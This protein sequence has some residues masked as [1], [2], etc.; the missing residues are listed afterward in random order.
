M[1]VGH[2][3]GCTAHAAKQ[4]SKPRIIKPYMI[5]LILCIVILPLVLGEV[6]M[7]MREVEMHNTHF[8]TVYR[9]LLV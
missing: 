8:D 7:T 4:E 1:I 5:N 3:G 9:A 2:T 6:L